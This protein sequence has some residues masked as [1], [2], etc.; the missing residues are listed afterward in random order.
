MSVR[1][2][3]PSVAVSMFHIRN[4]FDQNLRND[5]I[6]IAYVGWVAQRVDPFTSNL[7]MGS[8]RGGQPKIGSRRMDT[9]QFR[10]KGRQTS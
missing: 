10:W 6:R 8:K 2:L 1:F 4:K 3:S 9:A 5:E 7:E